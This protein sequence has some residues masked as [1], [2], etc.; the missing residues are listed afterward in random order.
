MDRAASKE[1]GQATLEY[2][3][4][5]AFVLVLA[6]ALLSWVGGALGRRSG[7]LA[8]HLTEHLTT[9]VCEGMCL[10]HGFENGMDAGCG[11]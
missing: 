1:G 8:C 9:G 10:Y 7:M 2:V 5:L 3:L 4:V 6:W 11:P